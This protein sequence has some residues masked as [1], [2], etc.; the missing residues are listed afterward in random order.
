[1]IFFEHRQFR[2]AKL[3]KHGRKLEKFWHSLLQSAI[4]SG[5]A[6]VG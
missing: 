5:S 4:L 2:A 3:M 1:L 6:E